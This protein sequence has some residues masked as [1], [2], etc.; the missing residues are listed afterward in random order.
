[1][2]SVRCPVCFSSPA[3]K[4]FTKESYP[5]HG[6][7]ICGCEFLDPQPSD[8]VLAD[9]YGAQYFLGDHD[10]SF[11]QRVAALKSATAALYLDQLAPVLAAG[12][13][14]LL[15]VG[16][17]TGDF[18]LEAQSRSLEV[19]G[20]EYSPVSVARANQ[21]LGREV[22]LRGTIDDLSLPSDHFDVIAACDVIEHTR[23]P[24][25]FLE[26]ARELLCP[27]GIVFLVTPSLDSWSRKLLGARW[28][29]YKVEH[30]FY[31]G[32]RSL[33]RLLADTGFLNPVFCRNRK[34]LS[35]DYVHR[36]FERFQVAGLTQ[37]FQLARQCAPESL[38]QRKWV[39]PAS[40]VFVTAQ[41]PQPPN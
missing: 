24:R 10:E 32:Q 29:E 3:E 28:M 9:I 12:K 6:C 17:G 7:T 19:S 34:V 31:F 35:L 27:G 5:V 41:K 25:A 8:G 21:R 2:A 13:K 23:S 16:C 33:A 26:R 14:R 20:I 40:G 30:L 11:D 15:E 36:H 1:M 37:L 4:K 39:V 38:A 22:V 18:L